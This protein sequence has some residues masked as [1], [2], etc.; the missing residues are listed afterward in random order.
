MAC[1]LEACWLQF[2]GLRVM[3][4]R[5]GHAAGENGLETASFCECSAN[6]PQLS[7]VR[8]LAH[9]VS[10]E[11]GIVRHEACKYAQNAP[12]TLRL[13]SRA[14]RRQAR[15]YMDMQC[16]YQG[17][18]ALMHHTLPADRWDEKDVLDWCPIDFDEILQ[19]FDGEIPN[20]KEQVEQEQDVD[21]NNE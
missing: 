15:V 3:Y 8:Q 16:W 7:T 19:V 10:G 11:V 9:T 2:W 12:D 14:K 5:A 4:E 1:G 6:G 21:R 17:A 18:A 20:E 13:H